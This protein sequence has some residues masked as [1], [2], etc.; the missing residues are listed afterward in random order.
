MVVANWPIRARDLLLLC[1]N[2][3]WIPEKPLL[4]L[5]Q[6][7]MELF[8]LSNNKYLILLFLYLDTVL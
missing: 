3:C 8:H 1:Y 5:E 2:A 6:H 4:A 7:K